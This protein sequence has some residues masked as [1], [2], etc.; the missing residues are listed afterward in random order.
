MQPV[1]ERIINY[2]QLKVVLFFCAVHMPEQLAEYDG[3][4]DNEG[5]RELPD[6]TRTDWEGAA[7]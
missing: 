3:A 1:V 7:T 6:E 5:Q 2:L 4:A